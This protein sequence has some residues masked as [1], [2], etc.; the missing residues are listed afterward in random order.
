MA[1]IENRPASN[2]D[3]H[4][5]SSNARDSPRQAAQNHEENLPRIQMSNQVNSMPKI[6]NK[7]EENDFDFIS[8][9]SFDS[10]DDK[11]IAADNPAAEP[12]IVT[13]ETKQD[14]EEQKVE[15]ENF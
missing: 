15:D 5:S 11:Q 1:Q 13:L 3:N 9:S 7:A 4:N 2:R 12:Q 6:V 10:D 14:E 8:H